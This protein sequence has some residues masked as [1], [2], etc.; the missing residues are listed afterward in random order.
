MPIVQSKEEQNQPLHS[1]MNSSAWGLHSMMQMPMVAMLAEMNGTLLEST[2]MAQ[3]EWADFFHRRIKEDVA[4]SRQLMQCHS[5]AGMHQIY[6][7]YFAKAFEQYQQQAN[8]VV[9]RGQSMAE[10]LTEAAE[11]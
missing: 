7:R 10:H 11:K 1:F 6:S 5:L 8:K 4:V 3:K 2:A 9:Q